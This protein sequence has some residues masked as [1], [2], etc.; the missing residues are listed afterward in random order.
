MK[1]GNSPYTTPMKLL[2]FCFCGLDIKVTSIAMHYRCQLCSI[3]IMPQINSSE[4]ASNLMDSVIVIVLLHSKS[5]LSV[6]LKHL[7]LKT[8]KVSCYLVML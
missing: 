7:L 3:H 1:G 2:P 6:L 8:S 4:S 5:W